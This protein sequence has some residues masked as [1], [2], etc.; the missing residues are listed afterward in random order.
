VNSGKE[1]AKKRGFLDFARND[2]GI[3]KVRGKSQEVRKREKRFF[4]SFR[5]TTL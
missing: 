3:R 4:T 1:K 5:M 2:R